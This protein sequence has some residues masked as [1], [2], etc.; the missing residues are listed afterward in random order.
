MQDSSAGATP[1]GRR[2]KGRR[3]CPVW[4]PVLRLG[5]RP[6]AGRRPDAE[7]HRAR[8]TSGATSRVPSFIE[9]YGNGTAMVLGND[10]LV[11]E[12]GTNADVAIWID[13]A[14]ERLGLLQPD[15][16]CSASRVD[17]LI[18]WQYASWGQARAE[19][20]GARAHP[21]R[22]AG[23]AAVF[24][25]W[26]RVIGQG[27]FSTR[28]IG[29]TTRRRTATS[30]PFTRAIAVTCGPSWCASICRRGWSWAP[31]PTRSC[32]CATTPTGQSAGPCALACSSA[33][34]VTVAWPRGTA[35]RDGQRRQPHRHA[36][37]G[38]RTPGRC[39]GGPC[40]W[41]SPMRRLVAERAAVRQFS[42]PGTVSEPRRTR[43]EYR[44]DVIFGLSVAW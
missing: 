2:S 24:G 32:A 31:T 7:G 3:R 29:A 18:Q 5:S 16:G 21:R 33:C 37:A 20:H 23:A 38:R 43:S 19:Q 10:D 11:P 9:L 26:G 39:P 40:S 42:I 12:R 27:T 17:D 41:R 25:R 35:A 36:V 4:S 13:R 8:R 22:R 15:D 30:C 34:G 1:R 44:C 14:G 6:P 28:A